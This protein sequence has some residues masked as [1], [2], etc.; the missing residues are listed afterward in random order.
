M[1]KKW[2]D[3]AVKSLSA[4]LTGITS[5]HNGDFYCLNCFHSCSTRNR[6]KKHERVCNDHDYS[7]VEMQ[8]H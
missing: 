1:V 4:L 7:Q 6:L 5:N 3:L 8:I 2:H